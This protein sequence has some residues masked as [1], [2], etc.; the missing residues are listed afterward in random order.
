MKLWNALLNVPARRLVPLLLLVVALVS[1]GLRYGY[2]VGAMEQRV[3]QGVASDLRGRLG[4]EQALLDVRLG[5]D[6]PIQLRHQVASL[7]L[8]RGMDRAYLVGADGVV[9]ASLS[10]ADIGRQ[11]A[12][13]L[14]SAAADLQALTERPQPRSVEVDQVPN[15]PRLA[16]LVPL[17]EGY[18]LVVRVDPANTLASR[19]SEIRGEVAREAVLILAAAVL[20]ALLL[21]LLWFRRAQQLVAALEAI[22][23]GDLSVRT[24]LTGRDE[25]AQISAAVDRMARRLEAQQ[26]A[27]LEQAEELRH[28]YDLPFIGMAVSSPADKR[29]L[30]V[31]DRLCEILG[32]EREELLVRTWAEMTPPGD[33]ERNVELF[34]DLVAGV[35]EGYQMEKRFVRKDG[36]MV[37]AFMDVRAVRHADGQLRQLF[38][39]IQDVTERKAA[40]VALRNSQ[41]LLVDAQRLSRLGN[42]S[43]SEPGPELLWS[44]EVYRIH[45]LDPQAHIPTA[46]DLIRLVHPED[47]DRVAEAYRG[48]VLHA[49]GF[50]VQ[51][52]ISLPSG[53]IKFLRLQGAATREAHGSIRAFGTVQ[54]VTELVEARRERDRL[55]SVMENTSDIVSMAD[56]QGRVFY[57][58]RAGY[59][60]LGLK[61]GDPLD[62]SIVNVHPP[63]AARRVQEEGIPTALRDGR[64]LGETAVLD[65]QGREVPMSQL[66]MV[67]RE[68]DGRPQFLWSLLR[69]MTERKAAEKALHEQ[70][71]LLAEAQD[72]ARLGN[73]SMDVASRE[74]TW[75]PVLYEM[76][77][78]LP[79]AVRPTAEA[80][81]NVVHPADAKRVRRALA[82][83]LRAPNAGQLLLVHR[84]VT[85]QGT[86]YLEQRVRT[87]RDSD[88]RA[89]R[90]FGTAMDVTERTLAAQAVLELKDMLEQAESVSLLGSWAADAQTQRL[91]VSAQLFC[92]LGLAPADR[93]PSDEEYLTRL[94]PDDQAMVAAD[95]AQLRCGGEARDLVFRTHPDHGPV[96]WLRR[97]ARR[98]DRSAEGLPPRYIG[99]LLDITDSVQAEEKLREINQGLEQRVN[100][101]TQQLSEA[102]RELEA[103]SYTVSHD[104][105]APLRGIDG[106]SQLLEEEYG[107]QLGEEGM[108]FLGRIRRGVQLMGELIS[109][110]LDYSRM[111]RRTMERHDVD[112]QPLLERVLEGFAGDVER[113]GAQVTLALAPMTL[114]VDR[115]GMAVVLRNL[116]GNA[117]KF[118][119]ESRP[120]QVQIGSRSEPGRRILWVQDNGVG[121][122]MKYHDRIFGI[123]QRLQR[124]EDYPGT[125]V[126]LAL[127]A[128]AVDRM[129]G[130]VWAESRLGGGATFYL[131]FPE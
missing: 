57:F 78:F 80:A 126:G 53:A 81:L 49:Q 32:Y 101:R 125:G 113:H 117:L 46:G 45:E 1:V 83:E 5:N 66:I 79:G 16:G 7:A 104:L 92:N 13:V 130:R 47:R 103:F 59:E 68:A 120:P 94:H 26:R 75:S 97:T 114:G 6:D 105:K 20:L 54:D 69:D 129:G 3:L 22:G 15:A 55:A 82:A 40:E 93:P 100:E 35:R 119:R 56:P 123:F 43:F 28:F 70:R 85:D 67:H 72:V 50:E 34:N 127:V 18:R 60:L 33:L 112:L 76:L 14:G 52:R 39:T 110:L 86:R 118:S 10:R 98:I 36:R 63:W 84:I 62:D 128:K 74:L 19:R 17:T 89:V 131:E 77:G 108:Q 121:F 2:Q 42:W 124:A 96:R 21:H 27:Q 31:N 29:W 41:A 48:A 122:D 12:Q 4:I 111:E 88:G 8:Y 24:A 65:A 58:N 25:L 23:A 107:A 30:R 95:M 61:P 9:E 38:T 73:W 11:I 115:E 37:H 109:D 44:E 87:E 91:T 116:I 71:V 64:W 106:Y 51:Y 90:L 99:T 102:N